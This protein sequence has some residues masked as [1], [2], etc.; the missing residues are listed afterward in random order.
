[1]AAKVA[2]LIEN[3]DARDGM[4]SAMAQWHAPRAAGQIAESIMQ[5][6]TARRRAT[7]DAAMPAAPNLQN[8][9]SAIT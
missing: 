5:V 9:Q 4:S 3:T 1:V 8:R 7:G 2:E 6:I